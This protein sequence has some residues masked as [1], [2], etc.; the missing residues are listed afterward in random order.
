MAFR[1]RYL[2]LWSLFLTLLLFL[3]IQSLSSAGTSLVSLRWGSRKSPEVLRLRPSDFLQ[4]VRDWNPSNDDFPPPHEPVKPGTLRDVWEENFYRGGTSTIEPLDGPSGRNAE[5]AIYDPYPNYKSEEWTNEWKGTFRA[6]DGPRGR[7]SRWNRDDMVL[8]YPGAQQASWL[9]TRLQWISGFPFPKY[10]SYS[11]LGLDGG[12]CTTRF[13]PLGAYGY[14]DEGNPPTMNTNTD[15]K[16]DFWDAVNW[17]RYQAECLQRNKDRYSAGP[18]TSLNGLLPLQGKSPALAHGEQRQYEKRDG[19]ASSSSPRLHPRSADILRAW[20]DLEWTENMKHHVRSLVMELSLH[21]GAE[22]EMF[23]LTHVKNSDIPLD[24]PDEGQNIQMLRKRPLHQHLQPIQIFSVVHPKFDYYRQLEMDARFT[25][26]AYHFL[27]RAGAFAKG[28]PRIIW[29]PAPPPHL[30]WLDPIGPTPPSSSPE[31]DTKSTIVWGVDEEADLITFLPIFD[32]VDTT[33]VFPNVLWNLPFDIPRLA[34]PVM[35][36]RYSRALLS[37]VHSVQ[38]EQ[39]IALA[40]EMTALTFALWHGLK[41]VHVPQP[42]YADGKWTPSELDGI[43][44]RGP[45]WSVNSGPDSLWNWDHH[46]DHVLYR[47][48]YMFTGQTGEDLYRRWLG[49]VVDGGQYTDG[50]HHQDPQGRKRFDHGDLRED[51]YGPLCFPSMLLH[52]VKNTALEKGK[53]MAVPV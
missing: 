10:G 6:C 43:V 28:Q 32:L 21:S 15:A 8:A 9:L 38:S 44:N 33:W 4:M 52:P 53:D 51:L 26:H 25:G 41:E 16:E 12:S 20:H 17:G 45:G 30:P 14:T 36:G 29:G 31:Q 46:F 27:E 19:S 35:M 37:A 11:A 48:G 7:L 24:G 34:S 49:Y 40:S 42:I 39:G 23:L 5:P 50:S 18:E 22:Y 3:T 13:S 1:R 47:M 2:A